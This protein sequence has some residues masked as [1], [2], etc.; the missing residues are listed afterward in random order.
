MGATTNTVGKATAHEKDQFCIHAAMKPASKPVRRKVEMPDTTKDI[1]PDRSRPKTIGT[2]LGLSLT[3]PQSC[4]WRFPE[5]P[6]RAPS[7]G[8]P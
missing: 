7:T 2:I 1:M 5:I 3:Q 6:L 8:Q 4:D